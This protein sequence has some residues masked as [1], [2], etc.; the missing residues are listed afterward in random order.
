MTEALLEFVVAAPVVEMTVGGQAHDG[1][2]AQ[3]GDLGAQGAHAHAGVDQE[4]AVAAADVPDVAAD[5][6]VD[7]GLEDEGDVVAQV[8]DLEPA[9]GDFEGGVHGGVILLDGRRATF[10]EPT[11]QRG[12]GLGKLGRT[13][14]GWANVG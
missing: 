5:E 10:M 7:V 2:L 6:L 4:V 9:V 3:L 11:I 14:E 13:M 12:V 1:A 8:G